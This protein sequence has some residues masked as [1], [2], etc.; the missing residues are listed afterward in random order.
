MP[1]QSQHLIL[2]DVSQLRAIPD[3]ITTR[4]YKGV[5]H[6]LVYDLVQK[7]ARKEGYE[8]LRDTLE[9]THGGNRAFMNLQF[10]TDDPNLPF[11][12][13]MRSTYD[14]SA[15][16]AIAAGASVFICSN[17]MI[18]GSDITLKKAHK[19]TIVEELEDMIAR[20]FGSGKQSYKDK[21]TWREELK[22]TQLTVRQGEFLLA[23]AKVEGVFNGKAYGQ[24]R[25]HW[26]QA[27][28]D[29]FKDDRSVWGLYNAMTFGS[30]KIRPASKMEV[31]QNIV[32]FTES[33][34]VE[35]KKLVIA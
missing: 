19:G 14:K 12:I 7:Q 17:L 1:Q 3:P 32:D 30:H 2:D 34:L 5:P 27:P 35:D 13:A 33:I 11:S 6:H 4:T 31:H 9:I 20:A 16:F 29:E 24:S 15:A 18:S 21:I 26:L 22:Q 28:F 10:G 8:R 25:E 23:M